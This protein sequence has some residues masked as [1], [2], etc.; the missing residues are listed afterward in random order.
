MNR[1]PCTVPCDVALPVQLRS[2]FDATVVSE[3]SKDGFVMHLA[4]TLSD[5]CSQGTLNTA[6]ISATSASAFHAFAD[7]DSGSWAV[8]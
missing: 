3:S 4:A 8:E 1:E 7:R 5:V 6:E 2:D